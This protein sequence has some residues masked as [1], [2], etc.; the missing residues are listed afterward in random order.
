MFWGRFWR[1]VSAIDCF[2]RFRPAAATKR[3]LPPLP[4]SWTSSSSRSPVTSSDTA[5]YHDMLAY[6]RQA[7]PKAVGVQ[8]A[9]AVGA[10]AVVLLY[11]VAVVPSVLPLLLVPDNFPLAIRVSNV[12]SLLVVFATGYTWGTHTDTNPWKTG[13]LL[14]SRVPGHG[15][16]LHAPGRL[17]TLHG[18]AVPGRSCPVV[19]TCRFRAA[20][21]AVESQNT[22][23]TATPRRPR[24]AMGARDTPAGPAGWR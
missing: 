17:A 10:L 24:P 9:D 18:G 5:L 11:V 7:E 15:R 22:T 13:L 19:S 12:V 4:T 14:A 21:R 3:P 16:G 23:R 2:R 6:L 20:G 8:R 1:E